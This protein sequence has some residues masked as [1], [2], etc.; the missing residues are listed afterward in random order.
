MVNLSG[1]LEFG[2]IKTGAVGFSLSTAI[3]FCYIKKLKTIPLFLMQ[4]FSSVGQSNR[5]PFSSIVVN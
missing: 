1:V 2:K 3:L 4:K 5:R